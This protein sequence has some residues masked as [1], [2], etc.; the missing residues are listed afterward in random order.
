MSTRLHALCCLAIVCLASAGVHAADPEEAG[1]FARAIMKHVNAARFDCPQELLDR[2]PERSVLCGSLPSD[3][4]RFKSSWEF[5][6]RRQNLPG[7]VRP[8]SSW[9][10]RGGIYVRDYKVAG[11]DVTI[12]FNDEKN[13]L[14]IAHAVLDAGETDLARASEDS[15]NG[16]AQKLKPRMAGFGGV[17]NPRLIQDSR[18]EP[19]YPEQPHA[20]GVE[21]SVILEVVVRTDG[22]VGDMSVLRCRPEGAGFEEA[23]MAA[24]KQWRY[25]AGQY[26]GEPVDVTYPVYLEFTLASAVTAPVPE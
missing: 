22:T 25:E 23:A 20:D 12:L 11:A 3:F 10:K 19:I 18:V 7:P 6:M 13:R 24:V 9:V 14:A 8:E 5:N 21:G 16:D 15:A 1:R 4:S 26:K 17:T 2:Y